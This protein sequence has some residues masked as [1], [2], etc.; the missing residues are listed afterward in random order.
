MPRRRSTASW[1][2]G[3]QLVALPTSPYRCGSRRTTSSAPHSLSLPPAT[4][5]S[6]HSRTERAGDHLMFRPATSTH[7]TSPSCLRTAPPP[8]LRGGPSR[9]WQPPSS[10]RPQRSLSCEGGERVGLGQLHDRR[11]VQSGR[12]QRGQ[13]PFAEI[14]VRPGGSTTRLRRVVITTV[15]A[16]EEAA[17]QAGVQETLN[18]SNEERIVEV[19]AADRVD[20]FH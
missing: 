5:V 15:L 20:D 7:S 8:A 2:C 9:A 3:R 10:P 11:D 18:A 4:G 17:A 19:V 16:E 6:S 12:P 13:E 14:A 1:S